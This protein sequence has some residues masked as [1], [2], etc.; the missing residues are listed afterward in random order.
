MEDLAD[1]LATYRW[2]HAMRGGLLQDI[3]DHKAAIAAFE[4]VLSLSPTTPEQAAVAE[5]ITKSKKEL[6]AM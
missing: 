1:D 6:G 2:Y 4:T 3:G 5:K